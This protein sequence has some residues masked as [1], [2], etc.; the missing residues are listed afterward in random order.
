VRCASE[1]LRITEQ[2][3]QRLGEARFPFILFH[4]ENDTMVDVDGSKALYKQ[5]Q[6]GDAGCAGGRRFGQRVGCKGWAVD[7]NGSSQRQELSLLAAWERHSAANSRPPC[8][9]CPQSVDK[10]LRLCNDMWHILVREK[11]NEKICA[12][13]ADWMLER[14]A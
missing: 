8:H 2:S 14:A 11:G 13:L 12:A 7:V 10:T 3:M 5:A 6:V 4:S 9:S 1:F